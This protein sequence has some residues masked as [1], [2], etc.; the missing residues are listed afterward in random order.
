[1]AIPNLAIVFGPNL[2]R[3]K[4][5]TASSLIGEMNQKCA[6]IEAILQ[7]PVWMFE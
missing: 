5:E 6:V 1:M 3:P 4:D 2:L 7:Q